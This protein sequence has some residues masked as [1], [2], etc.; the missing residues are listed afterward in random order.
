MYERSTE[1]DAMQDAVEMA[2][3]STVGH[4]NIV[5]VFSCLT[6]MVEAG[7]MPSECFFGAS[8]ASLWVWTD[9]H[10]VTPPPPPLSS[11]P[12]HTHTVHTHT[13]PPPPQPPFPPPSPPQTATKSFGDLQKAHRQLSAD[14]GLMQ[15][16]KVGCLF[17][18]LAPAA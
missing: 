12:L 8:R 16:L 6:D 11:P 17:D 10:S 18:T 5:Q 14:S 3:L 4:P 15:R 13:S 1:Q 2:V 9:L 7:G